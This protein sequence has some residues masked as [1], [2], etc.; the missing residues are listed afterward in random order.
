METLRGR[1]VQRWTRHLFDVLKVSKAVRREYEADHC[2]S[3]RSFVGNNGKV[4]KWKER[5]GTLSVR[6]SIGHNLTVHLMSS[7][8]V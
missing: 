2:S 1:P 3:D 4:Y 5:W 6:C 7:L 8:D